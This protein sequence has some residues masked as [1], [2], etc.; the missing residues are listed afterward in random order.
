MVRSESIEM[1]A[2]EI[3][4]LIIENAQREAMARVERCKRRLT[5]SQEELIHA[6]DD[7]IRLNSK[8]MLARQNYVRRAM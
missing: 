7:L 6:N 3:H 1:T 2:E 8:L 4:I 5:V